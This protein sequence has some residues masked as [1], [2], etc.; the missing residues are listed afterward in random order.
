MKILVTGHKG[1]IGSHLVTRLEE[2]GHEVDGWDWDTDHWQP[3]PNVKQYD[4]VIHE[5]AISSTTE[6]DLDKLFKQNVEFSKYILS[7]CMH[8]NVNLQWASSASVYGEQKVFVEDG[9]VLPVAPYSWTKYLFERKTQSVFTNITIQGFRYFNV[10]GGNEHHK[11]DQ[12]SVFH[13]FPIQAKETGKITLFKGSQNYKR[14][15]VSVDDV[16]ETHIQMMDNPVSGIYNVGTGTAVSFD[17][18]GKEIANKLNVPV[19]YIPMPSNLK[20][21]YQKYTQADMTK[22]NSVVDINWTTPTEWIEKNVK[23]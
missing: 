4:W 16:V 5:G 15:F 3:W 12:A 14:D 23:A 13:K 11:G 2:L 8:W 20:L 21:H 1:F 7:E 10:Y 6:R 19:E 18:V 22:T 17:Q 9:N